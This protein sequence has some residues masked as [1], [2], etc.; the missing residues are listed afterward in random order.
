MRPFLYH[1]S[2][3]YVHGTFLLTHQF[4]T[5]EATW[6]MSTM[7]IIAI[8]LPQSLGS[9]VRNTDH[10]A[11]YRA[12]ANRKIYN[13]DIGKRSPIERP[14]ERVYPK[15][16]TVV[17]SC[18]HILGF[19]YLNIFGPCLYHIWKLPERVAHPP[20]H[21]VA[22]NIMNCNHRLQ[23]AR[24]IFSSPFVERHQWQMSTY[25]LTCRVACG[26]LLN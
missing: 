9:L 18:H 7:R 19:F 2:F 16:C 23:L 3:W 11:P 4:E 20:M 8:P 17:L 24:M 25:L 5:S 12:I 13:T 15:G 22:P 21:R 1:Y 6:R 26:N 14:S 10:A